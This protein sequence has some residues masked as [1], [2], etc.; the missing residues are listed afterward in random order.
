MLPRWH[1]LGALRAALAE[2]SDRTLILPCD[3]LV[4]AQLLALNR[5]QRGSIR[6]L[7][8]SLGPDPNL[9]FLMDRYA[10]LKLAESLGL[11]VPETRQIQSA[12]DL[13]AWFAGDTRRSVLKR[14]QT[15]GGNGVRVAD[16]LADAALAW[17]ELLQTESLAAAI[18]RV[19]IDCDPM[20]WW[21]RR[22]PSRLPVTL[23]QFIDGQ[24]CNSMLFCW[25]GELR[26]IVSVA[27]VETQGQTGHATIVRRLDHPALA[28]GARRIVQALQLTGF[29]GL[30]YI[31]ERG[32]GQP[33]LIEINPRFT[34]LGH[35]SWT[36]QPSLA[37]ALAD[38][39]GART[40]SSPS[41]N[42]VPDNAELIAFFPQ[43]SA[44]DLTRSG[45]NH[46]YHDVPVDTP[47]LVNELLRPDWPLRHWPARLYQRLR[48]RQMTTTVSHEEKLI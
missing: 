2:A 27:V 22:N 30:D 44:E 23:Q 38:A 43:K 32:S 21:L 12:Y 45:L 16:S 36:G 19:W 47:D 10:F 7:A 1:S 26:S 28:D 46:V 35:L 48:P 18:K 17:Q 34:Q 42:K 3:D 31:L 5:E 33:Y 13:Q 39:L 8:A 6:Q 29:Y 9:H 20:A 14:D 11:A 15:T 40:Q 41:P 37:D 24:P 25:R 4:V